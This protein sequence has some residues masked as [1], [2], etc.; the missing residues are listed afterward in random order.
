MNGLDN[1]IDEILKE[2]NRCLNCKVSQCKLKGCPLNNN[3]SE[4]I[5]AVKN[6]EFE[7][8]Y[9]IIIET[10]AIPSI[11][12][13]VCPCSR[14]CQGSCVMGIKDKCIEI[15]KIEALVGDIA[16]QNGYKIKLK[17][18]KINE[19]IAIVGGGPAGLN[20]SCYL[21][22]RGFDVTIFEKHNYLG[23]L[24][25]HGIP[26]F[27]LPKEILEKSINQILDLGVNVEY[28][29]C[30][31]ENLKL[32]ELDQKHDAILIACGANKSC[33]MNIEG[34]NLDGVYG[35]NELLENKN[36]P[37]YEGKKVAIIG[38]GN[39]AIDCARTIKR[40][41]AKEVYVIYRRSKIEMPADIKEIYEAE[42][43]GIQFLFQNNLVKI[44]GKDK[45]EEIELI[46]TRLVEIDG[47]IRKKPI[48]VENSNYLMKMDYVVMAIGSKPEEFVDK[49]DLNLNKYGYIEVN[50]NKHTEKNKVFA[51]GDVIGEKAT[52]AWAA[53]SG[54]VAA[55][56]IE[57]FLKQI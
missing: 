32:S 47:E 43:E 3:I 55:E 54:M 16:F 39:V 9:Q 28:N 10:N 48:D 42:E 1:N 40:L 13:R 41:N 38:G 44:L 37:K 30:L 20:A 15:G 52:V 50:Q 21:A 4:M 23:G 6:K 26:E 5:E 34:E 51:C 45:V 31:G 19:K 53:K 33:K 46:K 25:A 7:K 56:A 14:Q 29:K 2:A 35:G 22:R 36:H 8:A 17:C 24:L 49:F 27:R 12:G 11:T 57:K 18:D